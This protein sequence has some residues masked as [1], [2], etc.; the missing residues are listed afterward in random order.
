MLEKKL[1]RVPI[2]GENGKLTNLISQSS[3]MEF[4][5]HHR[6]EW[7]AGIGRTT[8]QQLHLPEQSQHN[9]A[10]IVSVNEDHTALG[11]SKEELYLILL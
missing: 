11:F 10:P 8:M 4:I 1:H 2:M 7:E 9:G 5:W 3:V 6:A